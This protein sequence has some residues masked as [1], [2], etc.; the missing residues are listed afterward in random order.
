MI[1]VVLVIPAASLYFLSSDSGVCVLCSRLKDSLHYIIIIII[2]III[3]S[4]WSIVFLETPNRSS[5]IQEILRVL[6]NSEVHY[7]IRNSPPPHLYL[8]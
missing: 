3:T 5:A 6:C 1:L 2:I 7:R 4:S 8:S